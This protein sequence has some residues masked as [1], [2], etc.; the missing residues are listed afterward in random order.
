MKKS[1]I[2]TSLC[3]IIAGYAGCKKKYPDDDWV[4]HLKSPSKRISKSWKL[5][6]CE[7]NYWGIRPNDDGSSWVTF[8][9][10]GTCMPRYNMPF[11]DQQY[12]FL[13]DFQGQ[14]E[15]FDEDNK[16]RITYDKLPNYSR[17]FNIQRLDRK[18]LVIVSDS[19]TYHFN[20]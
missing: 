19:I 16:L 1:I 3:L 13:F 12:A 18:Y 14:W 15:L 11:Q 8:Q 9:D 7:P 20:K 2:L 4:P 6:Y 17:V 10:N 5:Q